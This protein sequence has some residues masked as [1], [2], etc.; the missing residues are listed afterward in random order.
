MNLKLGTLYILALIGAFSSLFYIFNSRKRNE[1][2]HYNP[3]HSR[4]G[5]DTVYAADSA[6]VIDVKVLDAFKLEQ[7][8]DDRSSSDKL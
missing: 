8:V 5:I 6:F 4:N 7:P 1:D 2:L 3:H